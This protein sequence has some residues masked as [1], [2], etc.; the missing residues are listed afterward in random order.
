MTLRYA[1]LRNLLFAGV[2]AAATFGSPLMT[3]SASGTEPRVVAEL[4]TSQ[5]CSSCPP[6]DRLLHDLAKDSSILPL[7]MAVDYWDYLGWPDTLAS[8][9]HS[10]R[11]RSYAV[12]RGD[13]SVYTPQLVVNG[14][15]HVVGSRRNDVV[16]ALK[17]APAFTAKVAMSR[18][19]MALEVIIDGA[20]PSGADKANVYF[21]R[22]SSA[23]EVEIRRGENAGRTITYRNVVRSLQPIGVWTGEPAKIRLPKSEMRKGANDKCAI[24]VQVD[25]DDGPGEIIG[26]NIMNLQMA[27][28]AQ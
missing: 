19:D 4:F 28:A 16:Q 13:R 21:L 5:G 24:L 20:L 9:A 8:S 23:E 2:C 15:S 18:S 27:S 1:T 12:K 17:T 6:A 25:T 3:S 10:D 11:Q 14:L 7:T 22:V 26:A